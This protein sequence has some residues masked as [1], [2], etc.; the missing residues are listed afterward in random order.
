MPL[1]VATV[2]WGRDVVTTTGYPADSSFYEI[3]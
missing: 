2:N 3:G 1:A